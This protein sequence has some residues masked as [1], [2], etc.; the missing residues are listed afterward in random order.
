MKVNMFHR[1]MFRNI[2]LGVTAQAVSTLL[3]IFVTP[4]MIR[5][6]GLSA[7]GLWILVSSVIGYMS[8]TDLG[9]RPSIGRFVAIHLAKKEYQ[10]VNEV[11]VTSLGILCACGIAIAGTT[12]IVHLFFF[13][14]F[15]IDSANIQIARQLLW[16]IGASLAIGMPLSVMDG[17]ISGCARFD[18]T[19]RIEIIAT[20]T[21]AAATVTLLLSGFGVIALAVSNLAIQLAVGIAQICLA[22][23]VLPSL[24]IAPRYWRFS[25][26]KEM[27][28]LGIYSFVTGL[29]HRLAFTTD[30]VIIGWAFNT[31]T[32]AV[33]SIAS[34]L[35]SYALSGSESFSAVFLPAAAGFH[36]RGDHSQQKRLLFQSTKI[37]LLYAQFVAVVFVV[38]GSPLIQAW[39]GSKF[40]YSAQILVVLT[41]PVVCFIAAKASNVVLFAMGQSVYKWVAL[42]FWLDA[43]ANILLS[44]MLVRIWGPIGVAYGT[45]FTTTGTM[46]IVIPI[47]TCKRLGI[48]YVEYLRQ[49][50]LDVVLL[51]LCL[52]AVLIG[53]RYAWPHPGLLPLAGLLT[54][55]AA[56]YFAYS[57]HRYF[58]SKH[59]ETT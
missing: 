46:L 24:R 36:A 37:S 56:V 16:I 22:H 5:S 35:V 58:S 44:V 28:G 54:A 55:S 42:I 48:R 53:I 18:L 30:N 19:Y 31:E 59:S 26:A 15:T 51:G 38:Y 6:L 17:L 33:Y 2:S 1:P 45:M 57:Y 4:F 10:E 9:L 23:R 7:Y 39:V 14:V 32:V 40:Q 50:Y 12:A 49:T 27:Y 43:V 20:V 41:L 52:A 29:W 8:L 21:R 11:A 34:R 13:H 25:K 47:F 3:A